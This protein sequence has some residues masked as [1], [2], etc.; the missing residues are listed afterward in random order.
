MFQPGSDNTKGHQQ[1][2]PLRMLNSIQSIRF[3]FPVFRMSILV[4]RQAAVHVFVCINARLKTT[5]KQ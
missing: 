2:S 1:A 4:M 3:R 5:S